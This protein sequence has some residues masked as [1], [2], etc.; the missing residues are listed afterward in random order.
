MNASIIYVI[1]LSNQI[2]KNDNNYFV[3]FYFPASPIQDYLLSFLIKKISNKI[4][5]KLSYDTDTDKVSQSV[6]VVL[7][8]NVSSLLNVLFFV[9]LKFNFILKYF[10]LMGNLK[11][12]VPESVSSLCRY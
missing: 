7:V 6:S 9:L 4:H 8:L 2:T 12:P 10:P 5:K 11:F 1:T 3:G